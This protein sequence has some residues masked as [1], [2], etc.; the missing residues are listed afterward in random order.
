[1]AKT[2]E[3]VFAQDPKTWSVVA[4]GA[5]GSLTG[6]TPTNT[7]LL[8]T[9]GPEGAILT[10]VIAIPRATVTATALYLF[11]SKNVGTTKRLMASKL[12]SAH[13]VDATTEIPV[14]D[15]GFSETEPFRLEAGDQLFVGIG[16]ASA[17]GVVFT[18]LTTDF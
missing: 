6:D 4:T 5:V 7:Q 16:V 8:A 9:A 3:A 2:H 12:M 1:M 15:F 11:I 14:V 10:K 17:S 13:T 18:G